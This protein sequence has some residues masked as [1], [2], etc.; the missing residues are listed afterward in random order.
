MWDKLLANLRPSD[1]EALRPIIAARFNEL[2]GD[3][4]AG[5]FDA[6]E[7]LS[8]MHRALEDIDGAI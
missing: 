2:L 8:I 5:D 1:L 6:V 3:V 7:P 4:K